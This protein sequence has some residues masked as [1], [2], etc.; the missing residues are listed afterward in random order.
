M[1]GWFSTTG[2]RLGWLLGLFLLFSTNGSSLNSAEKAEPKS[3]AEPKESFN[4]ILPYTDVTVGQGQDVTMDAEFVNRTKNPVQVGITL[5]GVPQGWE[6]GF[7]SR[8]PS[9]PVRSVMIQGE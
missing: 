5:E 2:Q 6:V 1:R 8:Y 4:L 9:Y 3:S 7:N